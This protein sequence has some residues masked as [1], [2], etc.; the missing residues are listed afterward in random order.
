MDGNL[1]R[2][3]L[4]RPTIGISMCWMGKMRAASSLA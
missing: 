1:T 4:S 3:S 2:I